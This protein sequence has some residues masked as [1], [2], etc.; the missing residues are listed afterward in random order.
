VL[1]GADA[2]I[3]PGDASGMNLMS[4]AS[5]AWWTPAVEATA[6]DLERRLPR[7]AP[8]SAVIGRLSPYWQ[9]RLQLPPARLA[10]WTGDNPSSLVGTGLVREGRVAISL[11]TS[12]T[13]FGLMSAPRVDASGTGHV[14]GAP[15][16]AF[17]GLTC[18][19]NG[20]LARER[21]RDEFGLDWRAFSR[22]L[23]TTPSGNDGAM[24]LPWFDAEITPAVPR[25]GVHRHALDPAD[26][27]RNVRAVVEA[28]MMALANHSRWMGVTV[29]EIRATGGA[30]ANDAILQVMA[31]VFGAT[32]RRF[33]VGNS[34][35]LGAALRA[36]HADLAADGR[37]P[38][39][40]DI[41]AGVA[42]PAER[43][44]TPR[45]EATRVYA[46]LRQR[47]AAF[48]TERRRL[49]LGAGG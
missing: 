39:W 44:I 33:A 9:A 47:Y 5:S 16:G 8:A 48:E 18:F 38:D 13:I 32:V 43:R 19:L 11:G 1:I 10:C 28:Q 31:D 41:V 22:A 27:A 30:A 12:D 23:E 2:P 34:A 37:N 3:D 14:F 7:I 15:T 24:M 46:E 49:V 25:P 40:E 6:P 42:E 35:A 4:L 26:A 21:V 45:P 20:S 36:L 17:M 29:D